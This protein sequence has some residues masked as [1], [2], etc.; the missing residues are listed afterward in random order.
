[1]PV[2][3]EQQKKEKINNLISDLRKLGKMKNMGSDFKSEWVLID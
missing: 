3:T 1:M 2:V